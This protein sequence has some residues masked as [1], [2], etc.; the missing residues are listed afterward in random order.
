ME[1]LTKRA[2]FLAAGKGFRAPTHAFVL[3]SR[4]RG[5]SAPARVGLTVSRKVGT[6][7]ER[8]RARRR[9]R[10]M[11]RLS[12]AAALEAGHDYVLI[13]R[14]AAISHP[15]ERL[16]ADLSAA[17]RRRGKSAKAAR[18]KGAGDQ[19]AGTEV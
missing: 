1:R 18:G 4:A 2:D 8:N 9:L 17:L 6:A 12:G 16:A 11:M 15:F 5:D 14:R 13:A 10:E 3:Q 19:P 7:T